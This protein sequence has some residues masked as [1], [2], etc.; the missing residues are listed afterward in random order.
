MNSLGALIPL[1][2]MSIPIVAIVARHR[3]RMAEIAAM[4]LATRGNAEFEAQG[5]SL[6]LATDKLQQLEERVRVL[7]RIVTDPASDTARQIEALRDMPTP[8]PRVSIAKGN[9]A[10]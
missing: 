9:L 5:H 7:E 8:A 4:G 10:I 6:R 2:G 1:M 3:R